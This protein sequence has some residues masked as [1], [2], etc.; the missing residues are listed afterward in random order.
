MEPPFFI[1]KVLQLFLGVDQPSRLVAEK[2]IDLLS[3]NHR[4]HL[5]VAKFRMGH[6]LALSIFSA[7]VIG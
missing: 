4:S 3:F 5:A 2:N 1:L 7:A 6:C